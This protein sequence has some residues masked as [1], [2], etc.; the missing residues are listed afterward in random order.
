MVFR[1]LEVL[2]DCPAPEDAERQERAW[3]AHYARAGVVLNRAMKPRPSVARRADNR[4]G[5]VKGCGPAAVE[6]A[7]TVCP[8]SKPL[9]RVSEQDISGAGAAGTEPC[10]VVD[11]AVRSC[12]IT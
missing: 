4:A 10:G 1:V 5:L 6:A 3:I 11:A 2:G 12:P 9:T 8:G 7:P